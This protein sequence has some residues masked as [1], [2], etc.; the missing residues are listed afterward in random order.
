MHRAVGGKHA[1]RKERDALQVVSPPVLAVLICLVYLTQGAGRPHQHAPISSSGYI[2]DANCSVQNATSGVTVT[3][4][5][6]YIASGVTVT[7]TS[8][9]TAC[10]LGRAKGKLV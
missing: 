9:A 6:H 8:Q 10:V 5:H 4:C 1:T 3:E 2:H 7:T